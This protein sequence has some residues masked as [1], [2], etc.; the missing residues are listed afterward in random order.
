MRSNFLLGEIIVTDAARQK[1]KRE[2]LDLV[3]R[4]A[5]NDHGSASLRQHRRNLTAMR[6]AGE[7][8]SR[9]A[10]DPTDPTQGFVLV[11][12]QPAWGSTTVKLESE[13]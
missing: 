11:V 7:I 13:A 3:A 9:Y 10:V 2:P 12:T 5:V 6:D 4:H 8:V 1:L